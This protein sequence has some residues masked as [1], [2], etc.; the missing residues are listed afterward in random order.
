MLLL[1]LLYSTIWAGRIQVPCMASASLLRVAMFDDTGSLK[2]LNPTI[3]NH[4]SKQS[5][6]ILVCVFVISA[7]C[8]R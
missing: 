3:V 4:L 8:D 2:Q 1:L 7:R 6:N 5:I